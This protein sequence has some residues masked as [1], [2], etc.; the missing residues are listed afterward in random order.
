MQHM[1]TTQNVPHTDSV[2][3]WLWVRVRV[4]VSIDNNEMKVSTAN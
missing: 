4:R 2:V 3:H 1:N